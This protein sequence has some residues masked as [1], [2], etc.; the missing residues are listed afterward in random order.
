[1]PKLPG[2]LAGCAQL[3]FGPLGFAQSLP[4]VNPTLR[5]EF[6]NGKPDGD[7]ASVAEPDLQYKEIKIE[8]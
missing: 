6:T 7:Q 2:G 3:C 4:T 8:L 1:L 5:P